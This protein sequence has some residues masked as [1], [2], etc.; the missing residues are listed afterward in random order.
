MAGLLPELRKQRPPQET[1]DA[2]LFKPGKYP[3]RSFADR[4]WNGRGS[5][6]ASTAYVV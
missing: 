1:W 5:L 2:I 4:K 6:H 3:W